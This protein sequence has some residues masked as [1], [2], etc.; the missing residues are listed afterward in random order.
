MT[1]ALHKHNISRALQKKYVFFNKDGTPVSSTDSAKIV[2]KMEAQNPDFASRQEQF[3]GWINDFMKAWAVDTGLMSENMHLMLKDM[4][5]HYVPTNRSFQ[6]HEELFG[7]GYGGKGFVDKS[8][9][10]KRAQKGGST[11]DIVDLQESVVQLV[12]KTVRT[13]KMNEVGQELVKAIQ[14]NAAMNEI[15]SIVD[16]PD[17][18]VD[19]VVRVLVD[20]EPLF[21]EVHN[22]QLLE[23][24]EQ[25]HTAEFDKVTE[26]VRKINGGVKQL[27]TSKNP[28]FAI[29]NTM[30]DYQ[31][32]MVN[33]TEVNVFK[34]W[35]NIG[36]AVKQVAKD[37]KGQLN[38]NDT[39]F[40]YKAMGVG[41]SGIMAKDNARTVSN[42]TGKK[43]I[44][45]KNTGA[46]EGYKEFGPLH[47]GWNKFNELLEVVT[48]STE[49][50]FR[51]A[52]FIGA[53]ERG[54]TPEE[55]TLKAMEVTVDFNRS[56]DYTRQVDAYVK[57]LNAGV[58]GLD[59]LGRQLKKHPIQTINRSAMHIALPALLLAGINSGD[60]EY[61][62]LSDRVKDNNFLI[63]LYLFGGEEGKY[64][65]LPKA[66][67][68]GIVAM[69]CERLVYGRGFDGLGTSV[70]ENI[71]PA[72]PITDNIIFDIAR[73]Y[74]DEAKDFAGRYIVPAS[75]Q[76]LDAKEQYDEDTTVLAK[77]LGQMLNFSPKKIDYYLDGYTGIIGDLLMPLLTPSTYANKD[78]VASKLLAP[79]TNKFVSDN[80]YSSG[81]SSTYYDNLDTVTKLINSEQ[82]GMSTAEKRAYTS[83]TEEI[84]NYVK[85]EYGDDIDDLTAM[86]KDD[87]LSNK[88]K[89]ELRR[90]RN[91]AYKKANELYS[92]LLPPKN[93]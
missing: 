84:K 30:R 31:T 16:K 69:L 23:M 89:R 41:G 2:A 37:I 36:K 20:G 1:Y 63:P 61:E 13:A 25:V 51:L 11:R 87:S 14:S 6:D 75:M 62:M 88:E 32:Y 54:A 47:K 64:L 79:V 90:L 55:A 21:V 35:N 70:M 29:T 28:L 9:P 81:V 57:Y 8:K 85:K 44:V 40:I 71:A 53:M 46:I 4:Y 65:K 77:K 91:K 33:S 26:V 86:L 93:S 39:M 76:D 92:L 49:T 34:R 27:I 18:N 45:N 5:N 83:P 10:T 38:E 48:G 72:N 42:I 50:T 80:A 59:R 67:E 43:A 56:G 52:E 19:N 82:S 7:G 3:T 12:T 68:Y 17:I 24:L 74:D 78:D 73:A 60:D 66:R 58:Q 15:A 22:K